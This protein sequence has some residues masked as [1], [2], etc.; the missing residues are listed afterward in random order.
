MDSRLGWTH[1]H[2]REPC[3]EIGEY[4]KDYDEHRDREQREVVELA[5]EE[6]TL[7]QGQGAGPQFPGGRGMRWRGGTVLRP[8]ADP[9]FERVEELW[10]RHAAAFI[11][12]IGQSAC[13]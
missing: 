1:E 10:P 5:E 3:R 4:A 6:L 12:E 2:R 9:R 13:C 8:L 7:W 11:Q